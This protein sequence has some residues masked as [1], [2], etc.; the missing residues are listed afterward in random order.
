MKKY[1]I[2]GISRCNTQL[3][4]I[5]LIQDSYICT[6]SDSLIRDFAIS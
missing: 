3:C 5:H 2:I 6:Y 1:P 4:W